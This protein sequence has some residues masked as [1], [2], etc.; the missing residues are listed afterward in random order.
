MMPVVSSVVTDS[1]WRKLEETY[2]LKGMSLA[3]LGFEGH[4][5]TD[6]VSPDD[7]QQALSAS[8]RPSL[9]WRLT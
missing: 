4:W 7:R 6:G 9:R 3:Q 2:H 5:L 8:C 1:E